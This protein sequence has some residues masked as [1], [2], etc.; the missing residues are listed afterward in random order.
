MEH[1]AYVLFGL[2][3]LGGFL[4]A[5]LRSSALRGYRRLL[6]RVTD[7]DPNV[8][9]RGT[10]D[11]RRVEIG[12]TG[13]SRSDRRSAGLVLGV[14]C[15]TSLRVEAHARSL[16]TSARTALGVYRDSATGIDSLDRRFVFL[17][18]EPDAKALLER[19]AVREALLTLADTRVD[20]LLLANGWLTAEVPMSFALPPSRERVWSVLAAMTAVAAVAE[21]AAAVHG[22]SDDPAWPA[23]RAED[24]AI[25]APARIATFFMAMSLAYFIVGPF[26]NFNGRIPSMTR[27]VIVEARFPVLALLA[28]VGGFISSLVAPRG[29]ALCALELSWPLIVHTMIVAIIYILLIMTG[30]PEIQEAFGRE[31]EAIPVGTKTSGFA[32]AIGFGG[33][34]V[35]ALLARRL[36]RKP[37][38]S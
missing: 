35:G 15:P 21:P 34:F 33:G 17:F 37:E 30:A 38:G 32:A 28:T 11:G 25:L 27:L 26:W 19:E 24:G 18:L 6:D 8:A 4:V 23:T 10:I 16:A 12:Y 36:D 31:L 14:E 20:H 13:A 7:I 5:G 29:A 3:T 1:E 22:V 9:A 2:I